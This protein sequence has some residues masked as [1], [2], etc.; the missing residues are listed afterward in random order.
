MIFIASAMML[1]QATRGRLYK[2]TMASQARLTVTTAAEVFLEALETQEITDAQLDA[3]L[4]GTGET[5]APKQRH[6]DNSQK[7]KM[8]VNG[9]P[10]M[11]S[12]SNNC[13]YLD[14][15]FPDTSNTNIVYADFTT[16]IGDETENVRAILKVDNHKSNLGGR[17]SNQIE[18]AAN[19][20]TSELRFTKGVGMYNTDLFSSNP[21]DNTILLR[22]DGAHEQTSGSIFFSDLIFGGGNGIVTELGGGNYYHGDMIFLKGSY[23]GTV[24]DFGCID[25]NMY[26]LGDDSNDWSFKFNSANSWGKISNDTKIVFQGKMVHSDPNDESSSL[27]YQGRF[28]QDYTKNNPDVDDTGYIKNLFNGTTDGGYGSSTRA[29]FVTSSGNSVATAD[30]NLSTYRHGTAFTI[31]N[32]TTGATTV[33][34]RVAYFNDSDGNGYKVGTFPSGVDDIFDGILLGKRT[35]P[36]GGITLDYDAKSPDGKTTYP[37]G[38]PI[39]AGTEYVP[40]LTSEF[41]TYELNADNTPKHKIDLS[42]LSDSYSYTDLEAGYY[43]VTCTGDSISTAANLNQGGKHVYCIDG[44]HAEDYRFYFE[45]NKTYYLNNFI[46]VMYNVSDETKDHSVIFVLEDGAEIYLSSSNFDVSGSHI[47]CSSG[48]LSMPRAG[49]AADVAYYIEHKSYD[50]EC[51]AWSTKWH[52]GTTEPSSLTDSSVIKYSKF[53]DS[54]TRPAMFIYGVG[55]NVFKMGKSSILEAYV[56]MYN[57]SKFGVVEGTTGTLPIYGRIEVTNFEN[58]DAGGDHPIGEVQMPYCPQPKA[59]DSKPAKRTA[60]SKYSVYDIIYYYDN[61][62]PAPADEG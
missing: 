34:K 4:L 12:A 43:L 24:S 27:V 37:A 31:D 1:T 61:L 46:F 48:F 60:G 9:V 6:T 36:E 20:G 21:D 25:G 28:A 47:L 56:G 17:F 16:I 13:T 22:S 39:A 14:L 59:D 10:G 52:T 62:T 32:T 33:G 54:E 7:I 11:S 55:N 42:S 41:P 35:A 49:S 2:N 3:M 57:G 19:V 26:F 53:Y 51:K 23:F 50:D 15:Y 58:G 29:Y 45:G 8:L 5:P 44:Q 18:I 40:P 38:T 30:V